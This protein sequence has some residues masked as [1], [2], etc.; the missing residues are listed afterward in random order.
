M[1][2]LHSLLAERREPGVW[3]V[4]SKENWLEEF[5][6]AL[7][8]AGIRTLIVVR[9]PRSVVAS[10]IGPSAWEWDGSPLSAPVHHSPVAEVGRV[11]ISVWAV[12]RRCS[13]SKTSRKVPAERWKAAFRHSNLPSTSK[14]RRRCAEPTEP[15][16]NRTPRIP[17]TRDHAVTSGLSEGLAAPTWKLVRSPRCSPARLRTRH[18]ISAAERAIQALR[19]EDDPGRRHPVFSPDFSVDPRQ[20]AVERRGLACGRE[21]ETSTTAP[22]GSS[23][24][25]WAAPWP[26]PLFESGLRHPLIGYPWPGAAPQPDGADRRPPRQGHRRRPRAALPTSGHRGFPR[27]SR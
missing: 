26:M 9:D 25:K 21:Q 15:H 1:R 6:P 7:S 11:R 19:T 18:R 23:C 8:D 22:T 10:T 27:R 14:S 13:A 12:A 17:T 24:P 16:G 2:S 3:I 4:A 5:G 20:L